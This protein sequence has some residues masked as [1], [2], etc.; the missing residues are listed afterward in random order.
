MHAVI[1]TGGK[2]YRVAEQD[3]IRI[4]KIV[5]DEGEVV[6]FGEVLAVG[7]ELGT[8]VVSGASVAGRVIAQTRDGKIVILKKKRRKNYRRKQG[9]RQDLTIVRIEEI[10]T[11]GRKPSAA[12]K[13]AAKKSAA[14]APK[15]EAEPKA[16]PEAPEPKAPKTEAKAE[17][18]AEAPPRTEAPAAAD[19]PMFERPD[20]EPDD[21]KKLPGVGPATEKKLNAL[22]IATYAQIAALTAEEIAQVDAALKLKGKIEQD[23]WPAL[24]KELAL[25]IQGEG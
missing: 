5:G 20:G 13:K 15:S 22:G 19:T 10:L 24:A 21:L 7:K 6:L 2:Q 9:H 17:A 8:P 4:E 14:K 16:E 18:E 11:G 25:E 23:D 12:K 3:V 1:R